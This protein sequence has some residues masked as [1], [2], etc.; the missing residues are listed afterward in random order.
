V[1]LVV[2][3]RPTHLAGLGEGRSVGRPGP[4]ELGRRSAGRLTHALFTTEASSTRSWTP[5]VP[6]RN[7]RV[8]EPQLLAG[9]MPSDCAS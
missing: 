3:L 6:P 4:P 1:N 2:G 9:L 8:Q 5:R 7:D